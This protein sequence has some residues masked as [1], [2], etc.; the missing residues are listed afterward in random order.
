M[1]PVSP[2]KVRSP[3]FFVES[4]QACNEINNVGLRRVATGMIFFGCADN[5]IDNR[6]EAAAATATLGHCMINLCRHNELPAVLI[7]KLIDHVLDFGVGDIVA[8]ANKHSAAC[9]GTRTRPSFC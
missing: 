7:E 9:P 6:W 3:S 5:Q 8:A 2:F 4:L 1:T